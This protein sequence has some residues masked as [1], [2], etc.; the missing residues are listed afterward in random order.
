[1]DQIRTRIYR[2]EAI[3]DILS[4]KDKFDK[5]KRKILDRIIIYFDKLHD[6]LLKR[7]KYEYN[8]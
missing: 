7:S 5:R 8:P 3:Y 1:M 6:E 2:K 4:K